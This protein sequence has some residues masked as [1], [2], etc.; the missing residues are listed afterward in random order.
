MRKTPHFFKEDDASTLKERLNEIM[1]L[2][3]ELE[4]Q[5]SKSEAEWSVWK[6]NWGK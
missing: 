5:M 2:Y 1:D 3:I 6:A 4:S